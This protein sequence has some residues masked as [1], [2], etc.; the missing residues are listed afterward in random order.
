MNF[1]KT[2]K[3]SSWIYSKPVKPVLKR[4]NLCLKRRLISLKESQNVGKVGFVKK[5]NF[6]HKFNEKRIKYINALQYPCIYL[7]PITDTEKL[8]LM[9]P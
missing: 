9:C 4:N 6:N 5:E 7:K 8:N 2:S 1:F 3:T